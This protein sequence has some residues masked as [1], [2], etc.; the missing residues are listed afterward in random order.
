MTVAIMTFPETAAN[1]GVANRLL[2]ALPARTRQRFIGDCE[3]INL[4][5][6]AVLCESGDAIRHVYFP[7]GGFISVVTALDEHSRLEVGIVGSEGML[8]IC[9]ALGVDIAPQHALVQGAGGAL[10]MSAA[11]F[12]RHCRQSDSLRQVL[13]R[14]LYVLLRQ[15]AQTAACTHYHVVE[16]RLAR[17]LLMT[18][19]RAHSDKFHI[20]HEFL[21][22][23][24]GVRRVGITEAA[25][26]LHARGLI[27]YSRGE[28][29]IL[30]G[31]GLETAA[32]R[33]YGQSNAMYEQ[34]MTPRLVSRT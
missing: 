17:W 12:Q 4:E 11:T 24:L 13:H 22:Y 10:R 33:C 7:L 30:D 5:F 21:S 32:C 26:A 23:M 19:D 27:E 3:R 9:L 2:G 6:A 20:T 31:V 1:T 34:T 15:L 16:S 28:I 29:A 25:S 14:Y 18:R 8:G